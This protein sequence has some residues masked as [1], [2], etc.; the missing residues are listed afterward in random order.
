MNL[1]SGI[2]I[3]GMHRSGTSATTGMLQCLGVSLG[4]KL[5]AGHA[6][7]NAKGYFENSDIADANEEALLALN[8][9]WDDILLKPSEWWKAPELKHFAEKVKNCFKRDFAR[10]ALWAVKDPRVCRLLPWWLTILAELEVKTGYLIVIRPPYEVYLS[11]KKRDG[12]SLEKAYLLWLLHY[13]DAEFWTRD[14]RRTFVTFDQLINDPAA[15][16]ADVEKNLDIRFPVPAGQASD[17]LS[18][19]ISKDLI[20]HRQKEMPEQEKT[21]LVKWAHEL[22]GQLL[23]AT[24]DALN[25][26]EKKRFNEIRSEVE[27]LQKSFSPLLTEQLRGTYKI[28]SDLQLTMNKIF[29]SLSW[30]LGK[31]VRYLERKLGKD[32]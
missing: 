17:A 32:V 5:Y 26:P 16:F 30:N 18:A 27:R 13:L 3:L 20:H 10:A 23:R 12:F 25:Y 7:I 28:R 8:S 29:R 31:P 24:E 21:D 9:A 2:I 11:L 22:Y 4:E 1:K 19:F 14:L 15:A 6:Q